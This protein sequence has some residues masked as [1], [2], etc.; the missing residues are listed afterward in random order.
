MPSSFASPTLARSLTLAL[1]LGAI[2]S[3]VPT[4][5]ARAEEKNVAIADFTVGVTGAPTGGADEYDAPA[6]VVTNPPPGAEKPRRR[7]GL[8][9]MFGAGV[10]GWTVFAGSGEA[11]VGMS[12]IEVSLPT[13]EAQIFLPRGYSIDLSS[14][15]TGTAFWAAMGGGYF[16]QDAFFNFNLGKHVARA[17]LGPGLGCTVALG[18]GKA[19]GSIRMPAEVGLELLTKNEQFG[20]KIL[21]RPWFEVPIDRDGARPGGG[22]VAMIGASGYFV[23]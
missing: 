7:F 12:F 20:F 10:S 13:L 22:V 19:A 21:G 9:T 11:G 6:P 17:I 15:L 16:T 3:L 1:A 8:G 18:G 14:S 23:K 2:G 5:D 4:S